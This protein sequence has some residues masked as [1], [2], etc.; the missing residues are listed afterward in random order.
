VE[1]PAATLSPEGS[2]RKEVLVLAGR[3]PG[4]RSLSRDYRGVYFSRECTTNTEAEARSVA[5][6][7]DL[8]TDVI[9]KHQDQAPGNLA[10]LVG[11]AFEFSL[12]AGESREDKLA[13]AHVRGLGARQQ[14]AEAEGGA[15]R[16]RRWPGCWKYRRRRC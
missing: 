13:R 10:R 8:M 9:R 11:L 2:E 4:L 3:N 12:G 1:T 14:L 15:C 6:L 16:W 7:L 5:A